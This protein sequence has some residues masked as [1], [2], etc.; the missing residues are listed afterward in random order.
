MTRD[1]RVHVDQ[2]SNLG[3]D[4]IRNAHAFALGTQIE[5][6]DVDR[7]VDRGGEGVGDLQPLDVDVGTLEVMPRVKLKSL[8][9]LAEWRRPRARG[10]K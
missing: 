1:R 8:D 7:R 9:Q 3:P 10:R 2:V 6:R 5:Q 4:Q